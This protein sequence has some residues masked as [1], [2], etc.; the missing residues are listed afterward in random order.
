MIVHGHDGVCK[1]HRLLG[2]KKC[3][4]DGAQIFILQLA[5]EEQVIASES[6]THED[7]YLAQE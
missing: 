1:R 6:I 7:C 5:Q 3:R 2:G 4:G